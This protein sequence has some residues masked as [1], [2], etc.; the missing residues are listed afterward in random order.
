MRLSLRS[1]L[2]S[3]SKALVVGSEWLEIYVESKK[4]RSS[5]DNSGEKL[6]FSLVVYQISTTMKLYYLSRVVPSYESDRKI[7]GTEQRPEVDP[8]LYRDLMQKISDVI[9]KWEGTYYSMDGL[10]LG[11]SHGM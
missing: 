11:S 2:S 3:S 5:L 9:G 4:L 10:E 7:T 6:R 1:H 8:Y